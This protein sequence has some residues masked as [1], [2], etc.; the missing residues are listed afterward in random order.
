MDQKHGEETVSYMVVEKGLYQFED[1]QKIFASTV[2]DVGRS[3]VVLTGD[4]LGD[5]MKEM[6]TT[7][8]LF[9]QIM[10]DQED[11]LPVVVRNESRLESSDFHSGS[12]Y[13]PELRLQMSEWHELRNL[14]KLPEEVGFVLLEEGIEKGVMDF[15]TGF[16]D[17][18]KVS[19]AW[20]VINS[21][22]FGTE[23]VFVASMQT[24]NDR[25]PGTL[26]YRLL[27]ENSVELKVG[28]ETSQDGEKTHAGELVGWAAFA[29]EGLLYAKAIPSSAGEKIGKQIKAAVP[30]QTEDFLVFPNPT[31]G[32]LTLEV[33]LAQAS[34]VRVQCVDLLGN[35][36]YDQTR[37][38]APSGTFVWTI[39][40]L[41][42]YDFANGMFVVKVTTDTLKQEQKVFLY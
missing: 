21:F 10:T 20:T 23:P 4:A 42:A 24:T 37:E 9:S 32:K 3:G 35:V 22:S 38:N 41:R 18:P 31:S 5:F 14:F 34:D 40:D 29:R 15:Q 19:D 33:K 8:V 16:Q 12:E 13:E 11:D 7:P 39:E 2:P 17:T 36:F 30:E 26:R 27:S 28:E 6:E 25:D 1:G